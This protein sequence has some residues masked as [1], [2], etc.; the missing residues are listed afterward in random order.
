MN[1]MCMGKRFKNTLPNELFRNV[2]TGSHLADTEDDEFGGF[3]GA[4]T[5]FANELACINDLGG[6]GFF[7]AFNI[8]CLFRGLPEEGTCTP[9]A[10]K[11]GG[12]CTFN[13]FP[14]ALIV[15]FEDD[16]L[17]TVFDGLFDH[18]EET[19]DVDIT[20]RGIAGDGAGT[21]NA[22]TAIAEEANAVDAFRVEDILF[23]LGDIVFEAE[24]AADEFVSGSFVNATFCIAAG[25]DTSHVPRRRLIDVAFLR[26]VNFDPRE[27]VCTVFGVAG[28]RESIDA[29]FLDGFG[30]IEDG[31]AIFHVFAVAEEGILDCRIGHAGSANERN[32]IDFF[33]KLEAATGTGAIIFADVESRTAGDL[34]TIRID[35]GFR[36]PLT[37]VHNI[38]TAAAIVEE[39][40][41][42]MGEI[43]TVLKITKVLRKLAPVR[44]E[45]RFIHWSN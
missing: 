40:I 18:V 34:L 36:I 2:A 10:E 30:A 17:R 5:N 26:I 22:D 43:L 8:E 23:T 24:G 16:P 31:E 14:E 33:E 42:G 9:D 25:I 1:D 3:H 37:N 29:A 45:N 4:D 32:I 28:F 20:P 19:A 21:P 13:A 27:V 44:A 6:I 39:T 38:S 12:D 7:V 11:E 35:A 15:G 41:N